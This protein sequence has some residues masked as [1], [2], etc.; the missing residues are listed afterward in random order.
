VF[1]TNLRADL[2][3]FINDI[4]VISSVAPD[5]PPGSLPT[6]VFLDQNLPVRNSV[7][8]LVVRA[9]NTLPAPSNLSNPV[10]AGRLTGPEITRVKVKKKPS[11]VLLLNIFGTGFPSSGTVRVIA[12]GSQLALQSEIFEPPDFAQAKISVAVAPAPG[13]T[14]LIRLVSGQGIQ[15]NEV[16]ATAK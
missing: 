9:R 6:W 13:T 5:A 14:L 7:G 2:Q 4:P 8:P 1:G 16:T 11:G 10:T 3:I 15:S 12:N